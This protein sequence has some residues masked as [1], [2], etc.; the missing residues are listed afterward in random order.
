MQ[1]VEQENPLSLKTGFSNNTDSFP[2]VEKK[3]ES[4]S[5]DDALFDFVTRWA[6]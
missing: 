1:R 3:F 6:V 4:F 5:A 2:P